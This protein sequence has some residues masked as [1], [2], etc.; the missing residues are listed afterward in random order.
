MDDEL[1][2]ALCK[3]CYT[4]VEDL[5]EFSDRVNRVQT[6]FSKLQQAGSQNT[7]DYNELRR[8]CGLQADDWK[9]IVSK[10]SAIKKTEADAVEYIVDEMV[11][12]I[13]E[14]AE[15]MDEIEES[16]E[17]VEHDNDNN[18]FE[19]YAEP[20]EQEESAEK[21][22]VETELIRDE[23]YVE[24]EDPSDEAPKPHID[25]TDTDATTSTNGDVQK[26]A[27]TVADTLEDPEDVDSDHN[28]FKCTSCSKGYKNQLAFKRHMAVIHGLVPTDKHNLECKRCH[29]YFPTE[30]QLTAHYRSHLH[31]KD[32]TENTCPY[33]PKFFT[34]AGALK[35]HVTCIHENIKPYICDCCGK[36]MKTLTAL[37]EHKLVHTDECPFECP[38]CF[39][40]FK[41]KARL[42]VSFD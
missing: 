27:E 7:L 24:Q 2:N 35:R 14:A 13:D 26:R 42:K 18:A 8:E 41:N 16:E 6:L 3:E 19:S 30:T 25:Y 5:I 15:I 10:E 37:N 29:T 1:S 33:C 28:Q 38:I 36:G 4:L 39:R 21:D 32:K 22:Y 9:H 11:E 31:A 40:R 34:T 17:F 20:I 23:T 12:S